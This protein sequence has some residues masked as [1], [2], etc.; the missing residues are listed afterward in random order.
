MLTAHLNVQ[1]KWVASFEI[2]GDIYGLYYEG[3]YN[4]VPI[5][6]FSEMTA[7]WE[8][9]YS[10]PKQMPQKSIGNQHLNVGGV[11][12]ENSFTNSKSNDILK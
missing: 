12:R 4:C 10:S 3:Y 6:E 2:S 7:I 8:T 1:G 11:W 9:S 5:S